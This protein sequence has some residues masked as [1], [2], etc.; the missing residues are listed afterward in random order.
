MTRF[1]AAVVAALVMSTLSAC[2]VA[3]S[4]DPD[5]P[6]SPT[7]PSSPSAEDSATPGG[8]DTA[9][10]DETGGSV[11]RAAR[12]TPVRDLTR[13]QPGVQVALDDPALDVAR[14]TPREDSVYPEY[15]DPLVDSLHQDL[16][17]TWQRKRRRLSGTATLTF[18]ATSSAE[19]FQ[20]DLGAPLQV[21]SVAVDGLD[22]KFDHQGDQLLIAA[23]VIADRVYSVRTRYAGTPKPIPAPTRRSDFSTN[24]FTI[25][26]DGSVW[27]MQEPHGALTWYPVNDQPSDKALYDF[28][29]RVAGP[30]VGIANGELLRRRRDA[31]G[32]TTTIWSLDSPASS[33]LTT[34]A[35][36]DYVQRQ[37][38][39]E[40]GVPVSMWS[41]R[42]DKVAERRLDYLP[43]ALEWSEGKLGPYPFSSLGAVVV[44]S[45]SAM[46]TQT[47]LTIGNGAY[48]LSPRVLVHET[49]H[50]WY[51]DLVS[52]ADWRDVWM[53]EGMTTYLQLV[54][55]E[56]VENERALEILNDRA[57]DQ[58]L[59]NEAG[60]PG[61]Y[62]ADRF[63]AGNIYYSAA[64]MWHRL[65]SE[66]GD[67]AFWALVREWPAARA[68]SAT[69][70]ADYVAWIEGETGKDWSSFFER[71]LLNRTAP[72]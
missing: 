62:D 7:S 46:E 37:A 58:Q 30:F 70:R 59:R 38:T 22:V 9:G 50:Q 69:D 12:P 55:T 63:G 45:R 2:D 68:G 19:R 10:S 6:A 36:G 72:Q 61:K 33:Y 67:D 31:D 35:F 17:L 27:T 48:P 13:F 5:E 20:L 47:M 28:T 51:G 24:G 18:R 29:L 3:P 11:P 64:R 25:T 49:V 21:R 4:P 34:V 65:R 71:W 66:I 1:A 32:K 44:P 54:F 23:P 60:P 14:D 53:N 56:E 57:F 43:A 40:S 39:T 42:G 52:P 8:L 41:P 15:G 16:Q 26:D